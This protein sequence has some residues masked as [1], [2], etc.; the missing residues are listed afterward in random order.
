VANINIF[1]LALFAPLLPLGRFKRLKKITHT[2]DSSRLFTAVLLIAPLLL[3]FGSFAFIPSTP[4]MSLI[5]VSINLP[6][7]KATSLTT[8]TSDLYFVESASGAQGNLN[9]A[10]SSLVTLM[11]SH[12][13]NFYKTAS[14][15]SGLIGKNDVVI[16]KVNCQWD[17]DGGTNTDLVKAI[18]QE[19]VNHPEG[20]TGEVVIADNGQWMARTS[21]DAWFTTTNSYTHSQSEIDVANSFHPTYKVST[22]LWEIVRSSNVAEYSSGDTTDGYVV[23]TTADP[24]TGMHLSYPKFK[25]TYGTYISLKHGIWSGS[26]YDNTRLKLLNV[27]VLKSHGGFGVTG[28]VKHYMGVLSGTLTEGHG[29]IQSGGLATVMALAKFPTLNILD[30]IYVNANPAESLSANV[31]PGT[32]YCS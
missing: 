6:T 17:Q 16:I 20:F 11:S 12:G 30:C 5:P 32:P 15:P 28:C 19:I 25:T 14:Q 10:V 9:G 4:N 23:S 2:L 27:P 22:W 8:A 7:L 29:G 31:G 13:L 26:S 1:L 18:I 21:Q 24:D 3:A